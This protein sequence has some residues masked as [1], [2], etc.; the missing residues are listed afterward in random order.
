MFTLLGL[1]GIFLY[2]L[3]FFFATKHA[4][5]IKSSLVIAANSPLIAIASGIFLKE[6]ITVKNT[7][8]MVSAMIGAL[9]IITDGK[10]SILFTLGFER[11]DLV[12]LTACFSW[13]V[14]TVLGRSVMKK[15]SPLT[16]TTYA[17]GFGTLMLLPFALLNTTKEQ[18]ANSGWDVWVSVIYVAVIVSVISFIWWYKGIQKIGAAKA[19]VYINVMPLSATVMAAL[20]LGEQLT[21][22]HGIG[23]VLIFGGVYLNMNKKQNLQAKPLKT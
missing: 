17:T 12:L 15:F 18:I 3:C 10:I 2:N 8:G 19:S 6:K 1:T 22:F 16:T 23:A 7:V 20:F 14:Y 9:Y 13:V 5:I 11:I 4:P 21:I